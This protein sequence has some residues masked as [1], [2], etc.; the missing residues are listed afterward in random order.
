MSNVISLNRYKRRG[1]RKTQIIFH[2][3]D[4]VTKIEFVTEDGLCLPLL[5]STADAEQ[6]E[7]DLEGNPGR[8]LQTTLAFL[9]KRNGA[10]D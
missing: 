8:E 7:R 6:F 1:T 5:V 9:A 3:H 10:N 4:F 2:P